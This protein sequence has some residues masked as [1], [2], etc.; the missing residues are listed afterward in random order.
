VGVR[1]TSDLR[2]VTRMSNGQL[3]L[4]EPKLIATSSGNNFLDATA[5][6]VILDDDVDSDPFLNT[7]ENLLPVA[8]VFSGTGGALQVS[9]AQ[10]NIDT[11]N[12]Q[13]TWTEEFDNIT[14]PANGQVVLLHFLAAQIN[15]TGA[16]ASVQRLSLLPPEALAGIA[17][18]DLAGIRNFAVPAN[19]VSTVAALEPLNG[20]VTGSV[21]AGDNTTTVPGAQ[22][23]WQSSD[24]LYARTRLT[25]SD[26][27]GNYDIASQFNDFGS[28]V[29][30]PIAGF[31]VQATDPTTGVQSPNVA[32]SFTP[33]NT[34]AQQNIVFT[35]SGVLAGTVRRA[36][37][38][39]VSAGTVQISGGGL[40]QPLNV[41]IAANDIYKVAELP[42]GQ[43]VLMASIPNAQGAANTGIATVPLVQG[44]DAT[45]D[46]TLQPTG[47]VTGTVFSAS[48]APVTE[49]LVQLHGSAG[50]YQTVTDTAGNFA[51]FEIPVGAATLQAFDSNTSTAASGIVTV[52]AGQNANQNLTLSS[53]GVVTGLV[54]S[55]Q[56]SPVAGAQV[57][58]TAVNGTFAVVT[59]SDG[60]YSFSQ[61]APG[62]VTAQATD[63]STGFSGNASGT[64]SL[65]GQRVAIDIRVMAFGK[66]TGTIFQAD[67]IKGRICN[68]GQDANPQKR[69]RNRF[70]AGTTRRENDR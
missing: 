38:D 10:F 26:A 40:Q 47:G 35:N 53:F 4:L 64:L 37:G 55:Q 50:D 60:R 65:A 46:I 25:T 14:V 51:F 62:P 30:V 59:G 20:E 22:V 42:S 9:S 8:H 21:L 49:L 48:N 32:G 43:Y 24:P 6:W 54:T 58:I 45:A 41:S 7:N 39:V 12:S 23:S 2:F 1:L 69:V 61:V 11:Q 31:T 5:N 19:G 16:L 68:C 63:P 57:A 17:A 29:A 3:I 34:A 66:V 44:Q 13:G 18:S 36:S 52:V 27:N 70:T 15:R 56:N 67:R 28:S 33:G